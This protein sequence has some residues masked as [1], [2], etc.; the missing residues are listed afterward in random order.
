MDRGS[1]SGL[2]AVRDPKLLIINGMLLESEIAVAFEAK[3]AFSAE[4]SSGVF[5]QDR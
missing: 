2:D 3:V 1:A 4:L 5:L